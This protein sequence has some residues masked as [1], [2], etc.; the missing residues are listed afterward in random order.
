MD[1][2][3][4]A[5]ALMALMEAV[6]GDWLFQTVAGAGVETGGPGRQTRL[7]RTRLKGILVKFY[8]VFSVFSRP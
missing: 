2:E 4:A 3:V 6:K 8:R 1:S 7:V 5:A